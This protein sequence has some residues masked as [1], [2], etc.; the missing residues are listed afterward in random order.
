LMSINFSICVLSSSQ[1]NRVI[2]N[3]PE[4]NRECY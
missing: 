1:V 3:I 2:C 4:L